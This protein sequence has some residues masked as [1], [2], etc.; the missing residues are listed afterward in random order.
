MW[1]FAPSQ[2]DR[3]RASAAVAVPVSTL[4][5]LAALV[6]MYTKSPATLSVTVAAPMLASRIQ[7]C[8]SSTPTTVLRATVALSA[9]VTPMPLYI[10]PTIVLSL[11]TTRSKGSLPVSSLTQMPWIALPVP[12]SNRLPVILMSVADFLVPVVHTW[13]ASGWTDPAWSKLVNWLLAISRLDVPPPAM[14]LSRTPLN[15]LPEKV[16]WLLSRWLSASVSCSKRELVI[17]TSV[18]FRTIMPRLSSCDDPFSEPW[19]N[20][21]S[22]DR[23]VELSTW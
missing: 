1:R 7:L 14:P 22:N 20:S 21:P 11:T 10:A 6:L 12:R 2:P 17:D 4:P 18:L 5:S 23:L 9:P 13:I 15:L 8:W 19:T 16:R 3:P